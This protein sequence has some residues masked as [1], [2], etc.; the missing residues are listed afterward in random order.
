MRPAVSVITPFPRADAETDALVRRLEALRTDPEDEVLV[1]DNRPRPAPGRRGAVEIIAAAGLRSPA[2]A[3]NAGA[4][5]ARGDWLVFVDAD[6]TPRAGLLDAYFAP[7]PDDDVGVL[8]GGIR[9][10]VGRPTRVA[11]YVV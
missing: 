4:R 8:G 5:G 2:F 3:R 6:T 10:V 7:P 9:D 11:R 1:A